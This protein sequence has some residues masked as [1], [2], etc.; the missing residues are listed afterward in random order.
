MVMKNA[1]IHLNPEQRQARQAGQKLLYDAI[2]HPNDSK[3]WICSHPLYLP[4]KVFQ[5]T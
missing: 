3:Y 1:A 4:G 2:K 5:R